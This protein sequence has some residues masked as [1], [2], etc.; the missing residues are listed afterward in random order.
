MAEKHRDAHAGGIHQDAFVIKNL[1]GLPDHLHLFP[2]KAVVL[3]AIDVGNHV[4]GNLLREDR[5][6]IAPSVQQ[7]RRLPGEFFDATAARAGDR[8]VGGHLNAA[9]PCKVVEGLQRHQ[10]LNR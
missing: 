9:N 7:L 1:A 6:V 2:G 3:K 5:G 8:L 4:E 10:H